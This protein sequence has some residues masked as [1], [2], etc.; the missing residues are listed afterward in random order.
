MRNQCHSGES[1]NPEGAVHKTRVS[2]VHGGNVRRTKGDRGTTDANNTRT[3]GLCKAPSAGAEKYAPFVA[4]ES[5]RS[6]RG[7][8]GTRPNQDTFCNSPR[9][10]V[11]LIHYI[12]SGYII[13][14]QRNPADNIP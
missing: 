13:N 12:I 11:S 6:E 4:K 3:Y 8:Q 9:A 1:R 2:P 14:G 7:M 5:E 10:P